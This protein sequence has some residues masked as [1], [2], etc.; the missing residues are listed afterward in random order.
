M[1]HLFKS[2][3]IKPLDLYIKLTKF[4]RTVDVDKV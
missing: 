1:H 3:K 2:P 4:E